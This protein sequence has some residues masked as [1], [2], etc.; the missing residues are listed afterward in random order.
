VCVS[1]PS[2]CVRA[3]VCVYVCGCTCILWTTMQSRRGIAHEQ[4]ERQSDR[5]TDRQTDRQ[6]D[7]ETHTDSTRIHEEAKRAKTS[8]QVPKET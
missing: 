5:A 1:A 6:T 8:V 4:T 3:C 2:E 7:T